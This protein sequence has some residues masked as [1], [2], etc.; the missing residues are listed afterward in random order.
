[1]NVSQKY[2]TSDSV[3]DIQ[4]AKGTPA[5]RLAKY[6]ASVLPDYSR[7]RLQHWSHDGAVRLSDHPARA[8][9]RVQAG[10][11]LQVQVQQSAQETALVAAG[12]PQD[13]VHVYAQVVVLNK[14]AGMVNHPV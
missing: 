8:R 6:L 7:A 2:P 12:V 13:I 9:A 14:G 11:Q 4:V 3:H 10:A 1:M 5:P